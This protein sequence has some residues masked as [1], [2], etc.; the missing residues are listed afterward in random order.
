MDMDAVFGCSSK[1]NSTVIHCNFEYTKHRDNVNGTTAWRCIKSVQF[2]CKA[3]LTTRGGQIINVQNPQHTHNGNGSTALARKAVANMKSAME[4]IGATPSSS[5]GTVSANL[6]D[7]VL[8]ALPKRPTMTR[9][10]QRHRQKIITNNNGGVVL[11]P[12]PVDHNFDIPEMYREMVLYDTG[13]GQ[14]RL[15]ILGTDVL[16]DGLARADVWLADGTFSVVPTLF[17]QLYS[18]HFQ[19]GS[20][21]NPVALYCLLTNK[22]GASYK[23][24]LDA[25]KLL[26]PSANPRKV[27]VDFEKAAMTAFES[28]FPT[29][30]VTGCYFHLTQSIIRKV[31]EIGMKV[32]YHNNDEL[33]ACIRCLSALAFVPPNDVCEAFDLL[34]ESMVQHE[35]MNELLSFFEH[36]YIR[37]RRFRGRGEM[38]G[39]ALFN[40]TLWNQHAAS[41]DCIARTTNIVEGWHHGLQSLF[42]CHHPTIWTFLTGIKQDMNKQKTLLLQA[43]TGV[44][45]P[46]NH[47]YLRLQKRVEGAVAAYGRTEII[48]FLRAMSHLSHS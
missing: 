32:D 13:A 12:L 1:G 41:V 25:V 15:I 34:A 39:P 40:I 21:I 33:R 27:L 2:H 43:A 11:P 19:F 47:M 5:Q 17:F 38:Y 36:T 6:T 4:C 28:A 46:P 10:L 35:R 14:Q 29:A 24:L 48:I 44:V 16:L 45:H 31:N 9:A 42:H 23:Q 8:M 3:R 22:T 7:D 20:G 30:T 26:V 37:G 18:I